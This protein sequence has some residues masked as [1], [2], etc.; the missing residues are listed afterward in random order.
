MSPLWA[1]DSFVCDSQFLCTTVR[2]GSDMLKTYAMCCCSMCKRVHSCC[3]RT[4]FKFTTIL[5]SWFR[6]CAWDALVE[7]VSWSETFM[8]TSNEVISPSTWANAM[9]S[10]PIESS[11][12]VDIKNAL[13]CLMRY[14]WVIPIVILTSGLAFSFHT[15]FLRDSLSHSDS[16]TYIHIYCVMFGDSWCHSDTRTCIQFAYAIFEGN[17][18]VIL[19]QGHACL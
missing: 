14:T 18:Q 9:F 11:S 12:S 16:R 15:R 13:H 3:I 4:S 6:I 19:T 5:R 17:P 7:P 2:H 1:L 8:P 10:I